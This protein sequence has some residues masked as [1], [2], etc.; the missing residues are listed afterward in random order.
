M[1]FMQALYT[2][3]DF[4]LTARYHAK[5]LKQY[6]LNH[7]L[8]SQLPW[9]PSQPAEL[10]QQFQSPSESAQTLHYM[11]PMFLPFKNIYISLDFSSTYSYKIAISVRTVH[12]KS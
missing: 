8:Q 1:A 10:L 3:L 2:G 6:A 12:P 4:S 11:L 5:L 7:S 9:T